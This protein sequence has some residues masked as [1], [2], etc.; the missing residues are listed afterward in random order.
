MQS[1][2]RSHGYSMDLWQEKEDGKGMNKV[3][4]LPSLVYTEGCNEDADVI[5]M[6][7][8]WQTGGYHLPYQLLESTE[9]FVIL[10]N[11]T[12]SSVDISC[13]NCIFRRRKT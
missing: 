2:N 1:F 8:K 7:E 9:V 6:R 11:M 10:V 5:S 13:G 4:I 12:Y 3:R